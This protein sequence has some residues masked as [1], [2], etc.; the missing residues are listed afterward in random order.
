MT[1]PSGTPR[2]SHLKARTLSFIAILSTLGMI[3]ISSSP[4]FL[5][6]A[7]SMVHPLMSQGLD[8]LQQIL[9]LILGYLTGSLQPD[10]R[11]EGE[12]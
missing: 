7:D 9:I 11:P 6:G 5:R 3:A 8:F 4:L 12:T 10:R 1:E 2:P